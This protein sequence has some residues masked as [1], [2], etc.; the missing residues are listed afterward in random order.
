MSGSA[1]WVA[2]M[3]NW[4]EQ[5]ELDIAQRQVARDTLWKAISVLDPDG[6]VPFAEPSSPP[7]ALADP[8]AK[9]RA[10]KKAKPAPKVAKRRGR[11]PGSGKKSAAPV[12]ATVTQISTA[13]SAP[14]PATGGRDYV[15]IAKQIV[16]FR[17]AGLPV[18][19]ALA[20]LYSVPLSTSKNWMTRCRDLGLV[21]PLEA[22]LKVV[23]DNT[24]NPGRLPPYDGAAVAAAYLEAIRDNRRPIQ[25][26]ADTLGIDKATAIQWVRQA[27][28]DQQLPPAA[29]PQL[30]EAERRALLDM[31]KPELA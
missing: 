17:D 29:D 14:K 27:R 4:V 28:L 30:P 16:E 18:A 31:S 13:R 23:E 10:A 15:E 3:R 5:L 25:A 6:K 1:V 21:P 11:P 12:D 7:T 26:V 22:N 2:H 8:V 19:P 9:P 24:V 20:Q